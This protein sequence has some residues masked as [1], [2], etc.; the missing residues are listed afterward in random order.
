MV[1]KLRLTGF[2]GKRLLKLRRQ[3]RWSQAEL[4]EKLGVHRATLVRWESG[5]GEPPLS[6]A[7]HL[8]ELFGVPRDWFYTQEEEHLLQPAPA[9]RVEDDLLKKVPLRKLQRWT[10][11]ALQLLKKSATALALK[12]DLP[13]QR[14]QEILD[15]HRPTSLEI[16]LFR[17]ALGSDFNP[18]PTLMKRVTTRPDPSQ[19]KIEA[20]ERQVRE[21]R[22]QVA[23]MQQ[24]HQKILELMVHFQADQARTKRPT[25]S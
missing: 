18:T 24:T 3:E 20:L 21:L 22:A 11:P 19:R 12:V 6:M 23:Q 9:A 17:D 16:Q 15:G 5:L 7:D 13:I 10:G 8:V 2:N 25:S 14:I 4:A 1:N